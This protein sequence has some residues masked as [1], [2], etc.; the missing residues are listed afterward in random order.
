MNSSQSSGPVNRAHQSNRHLEAKQEAGEIL[1]R[2][3]FEVMYEFELADVVGFH[4]ESGTVVA[5]EV[6][7]SPKNIANNLARNLKHGFQIIIIAVPADRVGRTEDIVQRLVPQPKA[8]LIVKTLAIEDLPR[9]L[10]RIIR[11]EIRKKC[12][13]LSYETES[14]HGRSR[15]QR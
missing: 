6:E 2:L 1:T 9:D 11:E 13:Q 15:G 7:L 3:G 10:A 14:L 5:L 8:E 12:P 4:L